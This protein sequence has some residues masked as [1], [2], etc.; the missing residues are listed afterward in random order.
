MGDCVRLFI[1]AVV[2]LGWCALRG[3]LALQEIFPGVVGDAGYGQVEDGGA[4]GHGGGSALGAWTAGDRS[5]LRRTNGTGVGWLVL[6][7]K[8]IL[9]C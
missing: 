8:V 6:L 3:A 1:G 9:G 4:G 5:V 7:T 2:K